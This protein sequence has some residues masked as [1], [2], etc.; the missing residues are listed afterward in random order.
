MLKKLG[1]KTSLIIENMSSK[2]S[3]LGES[4]LSELK[5]LSKCKNSIEIPLDKKIY[6]R[7]IDSIN[8]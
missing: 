6:D 5:E 4:Y 2:D 1:V 7:D 3:H 8:I